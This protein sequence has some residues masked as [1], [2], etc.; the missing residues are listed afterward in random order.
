MIA[1]TVK[2]IRSQE[3]APPKRGQFYGGISRQPHKSI[4][5]KN[6]TTGGDKQLVSAGGQKVRLGLCARAPALRQRDLRTKSV[7]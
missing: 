6:P 4:A 3:K 2:K 5:S 7:E 1:D